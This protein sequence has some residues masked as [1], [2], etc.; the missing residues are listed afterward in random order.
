VPTLIE[1]VEHVRSEQCAVELRI[2]GS[3]ASFS[4]KGL[5][6]L[7]RVAQEG[8]TN[9]QRH[10]AASHVLLEVHFEEQQAHLL[11]SDDGCGFD[12]ALLLQQL[13]SGGESRYGL[14]G[15]QERLELVGGS[16]HIESSSSGT[17]LSAS[18][19]RISRAL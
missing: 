8:L 11:L 16:L 7:Y 12:P 18:V 4:K 10:A 9:I 5:L 6:T 15:I 13:Q 17:S 3:E 1:L 14:L 19:P 2:E